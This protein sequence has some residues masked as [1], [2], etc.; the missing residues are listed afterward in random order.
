M[1]CEPGFV[2]RLEVI[3]AAGNGTDAPVPHILI[4]HSHTVD[5]L[6]V[7]VLSYRCLH[8]V[9]ELPG[10]LPH[11]GDSFIE[12]AA[13]ALIIDFDKLRAAFSEVVMERAVKLISLVLLGT[14]DIDPVP[15]FDQAVLQ[16]SAYLAL[17]IRT[18]PVACGGMPHAHLDAKAVDLFNAGFQS[19]GESDGIRLKGIQSGRMHQLEHF[20]PSP[21]SPAIKIPNLRPHIV[22]D[23]PLHG[24]FFVFE[25]PAL[26]QKTFFIHPD[27]KGVPAAPAQIFKQLRITPLLTGTVTGTQ[28][29]QTDAGAPFQKFIW[30]ISLGPEEGQRFARGHVFIPAEQLG[31]N[32]IP[33]VSGQNAFILVG[34]HRQ[35]HAKAAVPF[36]INQALGFFRNVG[37]IGAESR[38]APVFAVTVIR[39]PAFHVLHAQFHS[40]T[41]FGVQCL[42]GQSVKKDSMYPFLDDFGHLDLGFLPFSIAEL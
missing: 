36:L 10:Y 29:L 35:N 42:A 39:H 17:R 1:L 41:E 16:Q 7:E 24:D 37:K 14:V 28:K 18:H 6:I 20:R 26:S 31:Q 12:S 11:R 40:R 22:Q 5:H 9:M 2:F 34:Y 23:C 4:G 19:V 15:G 3:A 25:F 30:I 8:G 32:R 13:H 21:I 38:A 33:A 27:L